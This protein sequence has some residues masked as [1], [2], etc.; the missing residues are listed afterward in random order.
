MRPCGDPKNCGQMKRDTLRWFPM[1]VTYNRELKVK[2]ELDNCNIDN[3]IPMQYGIV[4]TR[5]GRKRM[6]VP[7]I[8]NLIFVHATQNQLTLLKRT[9]S[10]LEPLRYMRRVRT[11]TQQSEIIWVPDREMENFMAVAS[12]TDDSTF[13]LGYDDLIGKRGRRVKIIEGPFAGVEGTIERIQR[14]RRVVVRIEGVA[15]V[16]ITFVPPTFLIDA[17]P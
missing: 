15:A 4:D 7:A 11:D 2:A 17:Q 16:A 6:L 13:F 9:R 1:R 14:N 8:H 3:F 10:R 12:K 5:H